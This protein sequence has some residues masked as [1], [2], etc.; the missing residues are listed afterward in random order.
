M[1]VLMGN[2]TP[3]ELLD[4]LTK[5]VDDWVAGILEADGTLPTP[6]EAK[7]FYDGCAPDTT[8]AFVIYTDTELPANQARQFLTSHGLE[9]NLIKATTKI[10]L[11]FNGKPE[12]DI[13]LDMFAFLYGLGLILI[14]LKLGLPDQ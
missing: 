14:P 1:T 11:T 13:D 7:A 10:V 3:T 8:F 5:I 12:T 6:E 2:V 4:K 9:V